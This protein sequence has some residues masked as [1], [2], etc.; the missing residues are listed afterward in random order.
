M[1]KILLLMAV[2]C[3]CHG[4][5]KAQQDTLTTAD[6]LML[7]SMLAN[8]PLFQMLKEVNRNVMY[9]SMGAGNGSFSTHNNQANATGY[10]KSLILMP[11]LQYFLK[12]GFIFGATGF[13]S[14]DSV[15]GN[16]LYQVGL[17]AGYAYTGSKIT[18]GLSYTRNIRV[19]REYNSRSLYQ[20]DFYGYL[21]SAKGKLRPGVTM[22]LTNGAYKE[23]SY[24]TY[25][26]VIHLN[27]P[28]PNGRDTTITIRGIDSTN[29]KTS[30]FFMSANTSHEFAIKNIF[31]KKDAVQFTST[32]MV[33]FGSDRL[34]QEHTNAI[35]NR[36]RALNKLKKFEASNNFR[37]QSLAVA[38]DAA[39]LIN[40]FYLQ[41]GLYIDY[42]LPATTSKRLSSIFSVST[43]LYF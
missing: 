14:N 3:T 25:T 37:L 10:V 34:S 7:D 19:G 27:N 28:P 8:D 17:S 12:S 4:V 22:G 36:N 1:R 16:S 9:V 6:K 35:F 33:N 40:K 5:G 20:N 21:K 26:R 29:N 31:T 30:F 18:T 32:M 39:Y 13:A 11:S 23:A 42:Y 2:C 24:V 38:I 41:S 15:S 43:G